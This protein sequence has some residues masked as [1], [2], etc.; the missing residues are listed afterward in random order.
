MSKNGSLNHMELQLR[1]GRQINNYVSQS[2]HYM[3]MK[4]KVIVFI[5]GA[6]L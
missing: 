2:I 1:E 4:E 5:C 6:D 3:I